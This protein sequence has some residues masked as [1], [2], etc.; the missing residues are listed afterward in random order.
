MIAI[1]GLSKRYPGSRENTLQGIDIEFPDTGLFYLT[2]K[3]G[4]GKTTLLCLIGGMDTEYEGSL[5][6]DGMEIRSLTP[7]KASEYRFGKIAFVF[8]DGKEDEQETVYENLLKPLS[9]T[10]LDHDERLLRI[11]SYLRQVDLES[12]LYCRF[13]SLSGGEK[14]RISLV[15]ALIQDCPILLLDE[16][17]SSL[18]SRMRS[19][20][21]QILEK[22][23][24]TRL[25]IVITHEEREIPRS[26]GLLSLVDA[27]IV[28]IRKPVSTGRKTKRLAYSRKAFRGID[29]FRSLLETFRARRGFLFITLASLMVAFFAITFSFLLSGSVKV[30]MTSAMSQYMDQGAMVVDCREREP[31]GTEYKLVGYQELLRIEA[32]F[33]EYV[34]SVSPF[35][36]TS[37]NNMFHDS[38]VLRLCYQNRFLDIPGISLDSFLQFRVPG[39]CPAPEKIAV[40]L[41][42]FSYE[43]IILFLDEESLMALY[44]L[45][46][47]EEP[48]YGI[49]EEALLEIRK[50]IWYQGLT[51]EINASYGEWSYYLNHSYEVRD[52]LLS[53]ECYLVSPFSDFS[54]H[55]VTTTMQFVEVMLDDDSSAVPWFVK[56]S[57]G[58]RLRPDAGGDFLSA[59]LRDS[60]FD[61]LTLEILQEEPYYQSRKTETHNRL[62]VFKDYLPRISLTGIEEFVSSQAMNILSVCYSS[63][64]Y[65][66]TASGFVSGFQRPFF[67][68]RDKEKLNAIMDRSFQSDENLGSFQGTLIEVEDGVLKA[69]LLSALD[70]DGLR[71]VSLDKSPLVPIYG[72]APTGTLEIALSAKMATDLFGDVS[73]AV[74]E[75]LHCLTL[76]KTVRYQGKFRNIFSE[77]KLTIAGIYDGQ[78]VAIYQ[79][80]LFP[81]CYAFA[82]T[83]LGPEDLRI[84]QA[85]VEVDLQSH[86]AGYYLNAL[87]ESGDFVGSFPMMDMTEEISSLLDGLSLLFLAFALLS[88][89]T[90]S[91]LLAMSFFLILR[92]DR[93]G[94]GILLSLGYRTKEVVRFYSAMTFLAGSLAYIGSLGMTFFAE[95]TI[96]GTLSNMLTDYA[97]D[98]FPYGLSFLTMLITCAFL[99]LW[100]SFSIR[101]LSPKE[102]FVK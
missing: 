59:F 100:L 48:T 92:K 7:E 12:K 29:F 3:S 70:E 13:G 66:Y 26:A 57:F 10:S 91:F 99:S 80:S 53:P 14:K 63:P 77:G 87:G 86:P 69:D 45:L 38:Q 17:T 81:L 93:K 61:N 23:S 62:I 5:K 24:L 39:E 78:E 49:T 71:F 42:D 67:F 74:G 60:R 51:L 101:K 19:R 1:H 2:G 9:I 52:I 64:I 47:K 22:E 28:S 56:K 95:S 34:L 89:L 8:Q 21:G 85:L 40:S 73:K 75:T 44:L 4:A 68:S 79:D 35:Y 83:S 102:A 46:F 32:A 18:D 16:P 36:H 25:V 37:L 27:K 33:P 31:I 96:R 41:E 58:L 50:R 94:I 82:H 6:V 54:E 30:A 76:D 55:F 88:L 72:K 65:T 97:I 90:S 11:R 43:E 98:L 84:D 15:R 20:I